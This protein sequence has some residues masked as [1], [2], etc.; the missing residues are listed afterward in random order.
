MKMLKI[1][2]SLIILLAACS[3]PMDE[4]AEDI[5]DVSIP[6]SQ[7]KVH[8][9]GLKSCWNKG[10]ELTVFY[11]TDIAEKWIFKGETG[12]V[13][14][15]I[16]HDAVSRV[17]QSNNIFVVYPYDSG[18]MLEDNVIHTSIP[19]EQTYYKDS[20]GTALL[21]TCSNFDILTLRYCTAIVELKYSGPAEISKIELRGN[22]SEKLSG[23]CS[24]SFTGE[25]PKLTCNGTSS[26][27][28]NCDVSVQDSKT[29]SFYFSIAPGTFS[30]GLTFTLYF[31]NGETHKVTS[32]EEISI[33]A[34][35]IHTIKA[36]SP[37]LPFNQKVMH[38]LFSDGQTAQH[39][40]TEKITFT[41]DKRLNYK[42]LLD[43]KEYDFYLYSQKNE[44]YEFR[45]TN[46]GGLYIGGTEGDYLEFPA[47]PD[48]TLTSIG[49]SVNK[50][51][52]FHIV[53]VGSPNDTITGGTCSSINDGDFRI[54]H[55]S[56]T[57]M[58]KA[59]TMMMDNNCVFRFITL[60]FRK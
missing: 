35:H 31:K 54:L 51:S 46:R 26:V 60:Y 37:V 47:L 5:I 2:A 28:L 19:S 1:F 41:R 20:Y 25:N 55:L 16:G 21:A 43:G 10:D 53:P 13:S 40:F 52:Y 45:N 50:E 9:E 12:D 42:Y 22:D 14:G 8:L 56:G 49:I 6:T 24:I 23:A 30:K 33:K 15:Q 29:V 7:T 3:H 34:G 17:E 39:P 27:T 32:S 48:Y 18:A 38:L 58:S 11:K 4:H 36:S 57:E 44:K 59:Y